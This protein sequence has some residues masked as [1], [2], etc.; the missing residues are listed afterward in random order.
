MN[1][2]LLYMVNA[3][4]VLV[5]RKIMPSVLGFLL[6]V[7]KILGVTLLI[8]SLSCSLDQSKVALVQEVK[9]EKATGEKEE[10]YGAI[11]LGGYKAPDGTEVQ[12]DFPLEEDIRNIG[13]KIDSYGMCV[14]SSIEM[15]SRWSNL[16]QTRGIRD[17]AANFPG[18]GYPVKVDK[19]I[20]Q[21]CKENNIE[22]PPYLQYEGRSLEVL[23]KCLK[24][25]RIASV[26][27]NGRDG[28]R[29]RGPI[30][31]MVNL[32]HLDDKWAAIYDNNG[33]AGQL[34]W[35]TPKEFRDR[36][37]GGGNGWAFFWL[38]PPPPPKALESE[39]GNG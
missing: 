36:W 14:M 4:A 9:Q 3:F 2:F 25:Y 27:Y 29:Y 11:S 34:I 38:T 5:W 16:V 23:E 15:S 12:I 1:T 26:T 30:A 31:H 17:W 35:M 6:D 21:F 24:T 19:Q 8:Y 32:V 10:L 39:A 22:I 28:V 37:L 18:G 7:A 13:S 33:K 20:K